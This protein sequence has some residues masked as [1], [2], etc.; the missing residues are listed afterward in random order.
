MAIQ[1]VSQKEASNALGVSESTLQ[2]WRN[3]QDLLKMGK[4]YRRKTPTD[5]SI[6]Y[7]LNACEKTI[8]AACSTP[9]EV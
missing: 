9:L 5:R 2:R 3:K 6:L 7:D 8:T 4:H 1:W